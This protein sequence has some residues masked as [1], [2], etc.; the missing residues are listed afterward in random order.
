M[1]DTDY[2]RV[3]QVCATTYLAKLTKSGKPRKTKYSTCS[4][5]CYGKLHYW[6]QSGRARR[7]R[8]ERHPV[9]GICSIDACDS[10]VTVGGMCGKHYQRVRKYG[11][12][13]YRSHD[14][15]V[16]KLC[17]WCGS[18][19]VLKPAMAK[20]RVA[21]SRTCASSHSARERGHLLHGSKS[22]KDAYYGARRRARMLSTGADTIDPIKVFERDKWRCHLCGNRTPRRLRGTLE[23]R[24]PELEHIVSLADGGTHTWGNVACSCRKCNQEKGAESRGQLGFDIA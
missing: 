20:K 9:A 2:T 12:P 15:R 21:C 8:A 14:L 5:R 7:Q 24:A 3:C 16:K 11:D 17:A 1:A 22:A 19:M 4:R 6:S 18:E 10:P 23:S 13:H